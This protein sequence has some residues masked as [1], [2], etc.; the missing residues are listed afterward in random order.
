MPIAALLAL[1]IFALLFTTESQIGLI[2]DEPIYMTTGEQ[3][4][5]W[6]GLFAQGRVGEAFADVPFGT[7]WGLS[8]EHPPLTRVLTGLGWWAT[9]DL[10][11][12]PTSQRVG[13][14]TLAAITLALMTVLTAQQRGW[15]VALFAVAA[16]LSMPRLFFHAHVAA[17]DFPLAGMWM[18]A[19]L[20]FYRST[21]AYAQEQASRYDR[22]YLLL[23]SLLTG[24]ALGLA[25]LTKINACL[26]YTSRCV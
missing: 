24:L 1:A 7:G 2:W 9:R 19:T 15:A 6:L 4:I 22:W 10:L 17:I 23:T 8:N 12:L 3:A 16:I 18:V 25:L 26:L 13:A 14:M 20:L 5:H 11:P 21:L